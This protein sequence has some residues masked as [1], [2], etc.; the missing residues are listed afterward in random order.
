MGKFLRLKTAQ[1]E[2]RGVWRGQE[3]RLNLG[4]SYRYPFEQAGG[5]Q[6]LRAPTRRGD[7]IFYGKNR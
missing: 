4:R 2:A 3:Q 1:S 5:T 6:Q 7:K